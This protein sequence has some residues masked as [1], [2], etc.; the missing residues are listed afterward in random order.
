M[1]T[2]FFAISGI[3]SPYTR[4]DSARASAKK[5]PEYMVKVKRIKA[6]T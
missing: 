1:Y 3:T 4:V 5:V 6:K 2:L